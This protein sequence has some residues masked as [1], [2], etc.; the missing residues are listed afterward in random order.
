MTEQRPKHVFLSYAQADRAVAERVATALRQAGLRVWFD[1][2]EIAS[3]DSIAGRVQDAVVSGDLL[4]LL[5]SSSSVGSRWVRDELNAA[6]TRELEERA[7]A[8]V[9]ALIEDCEIPS[10]LA[11]RVLLDLRHDFDS[12]M[13]RLIQQL[14]AIPDI[15]FGRLDGKRFEKLVAALLTELGFS[16]QVLAHTPDAGFDFLASVRRPDPFGM[17]QTESWC[18][19]VK[20]YRDQRL[21]VNALQQMI[22]YL[23]AAPGPFKGLVVTNG[24]LTSVARKFLGELKQRS[25]HDL[26]VV[27]GTELTRLLTQHPSVT[28]EF[29]GPEAGQ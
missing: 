6:L 29:F 13:Q 18:V 19:E 10:S 16:L 28:S 17:Q 4:L 21:S 26:R 15:D 20:F 5:L 27:D 11:H 14:Q 25:G 2:W 7:I 9:P 23:M 8:V 3:G 22:G 24:L 12:G 1:S